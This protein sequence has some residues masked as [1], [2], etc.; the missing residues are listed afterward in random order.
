MIGRI[1]LTES[2]P[3]K[4]LTNPPVLKVGGSAAGMNNA[5][6]TKLKV[7]L[8]TRL[9][10]TP[11]CILLSYPYKSLALMFGVVQTQAPYDCTWSIGINAIGGTFLCKMIFNDDKGMQPGS[12]RIKLRAYCSK[13]Q[14][15]IRGQSSY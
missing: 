13:S 10:Y 7:F 2:K 14:V 1:K 15:E 8:L 6:L 11:S 4:K 9:V 3:L 5:N 12:K